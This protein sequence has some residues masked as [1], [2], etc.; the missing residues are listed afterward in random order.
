M[1]TVPTTHRVIVRRI[2]PERIVVEMVGH[3]GRFILEG[4][5]RSL[6]WPGDMCFAERVCSKSDVVKFISHINSTQT[7]VCYFSEINNKYWAIPEERDLSDRVID[8][9]G[10]VLRTINDRSRANVLIK[11]YKKKKGYY[12]GEVIST[13]EDNFLL[14]QAI[15]RTISVFQLPRSFPSLVDS[16]LEQLKVFVD[17]V[18]DRVDL[19]DY[20]FVT[21]DGDDAKDF[22]DAVFAEKKSNL[23]RLVVAVAHVSSYVSWNSAIDE[24]AYQRATSMYFPSTVIPMLPPTLSEDLCSLCPQKVRLVLC[25]D[26]M[27]DSRINDP[28]VSYRIYPAKIKSCQRLTYRSVQNCWDGS[29][30]DVLPELLPLMG[31][32]FDVFTILK[33]SAKQRGMLNFNTPAVYFEYDNGRVCDVYNHTRYASE[34]M[35]EQ[36]MLAA[37]TCVANFLSLKNLPGSVYRNHEGVSKDSMPLLKQFLSLFGMGSLFDGLTTSKGMQRILDSLSNL[38]LPHLQLY[39]LRSM[40]HAVYCDR[41]EGHFGLSLKEYTHFTSPIRRYPDLL[42]QRALDCYLYGKSNIKFNLTEYLEHCS[43]KERVSES[44]SRYITSFLKCCFMVSHIDKKFSGTI[45]SV[46]EM[47]L[48]VLLDDYPIEGLVHISKLGRDYFI[49]DACRF[50]LIGNRSGAAFCLGDRV[51]VQVKDVDL[52]MRRIYLSLLNRDK[53][54]K[55]V[56]DREGSFRD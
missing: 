32:L 27:I 23:F 39:F 17:P 8:V 56:I 54:K 11:S 45:S 35:I 9:S 25:C 51:N 44:A 34:E 37:N 53:L 52:S 48:F 40:Q 36:C 49:F 10:F 5:E 41:N 21:I 14:S 15:E 18:K 47:G 38:S 6:V 50:R 20:S 2:Q 12:V 16:D 28:I 55:K 22:D 7:C 46:T 31:I 26:M 43:M 19:T 4:V 24:E 13:F 33:N 29:S 1:S 3:H 30:N 42:V